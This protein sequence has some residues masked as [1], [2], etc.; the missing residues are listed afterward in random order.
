[1]GNRGNLSGPWVIG[2]IFGVLEFYIS[3]LNRV[4]F[5]KIGTFCIDWCLHCIER[6]VLDSVLV[7]NH[8]VL[9]SL[10]RGETPYSWRS[11]CWLCCSTWR[12]RYLSKLKFLQSPS[13]LKDCNLVTMALPVDTICC[14]W[15]KRVCKVR[16]TCR[17]FLVLLDFFTWLHQLDFPQQAWRTLLSMTMLARKLGSKGLSLSKVS[18][19]S[20]SWEW[21]KSECKMG[22]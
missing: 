1:M 15:R 17:P 18:R 5:S 19:L 11:A 2:W 4:K 22:A 3:I 9:R 10:A 6:G 13:Y 14:P 12:F 20:A 21:V 7:W 8:R 16:Y